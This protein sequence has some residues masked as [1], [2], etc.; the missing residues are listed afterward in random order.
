MK[1]KYTVLLWQDR[2]KPPQHSQC[3][4]GDH[5]NMKWWSLIPFQYCFKLSTDSLFK[6]TAK[7]CKCRSPIQKVSPSPQQ[8]KCSLFE[9]KEVVSLIIIFSR[10]FYIYM[11][12]SSSKYMSYQLRTAIFPY[13]FKM[14]KNSSSPLALRLA[15]KAKCFHYHFSYLSNWRPLPET[16]KEDKGRSENTFFAFF[17]FYKLCSAKTWKPNWLEVNR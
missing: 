6:W 13:L 2:W 9:K 17:H 16:I 15:Y 1:I 12:Y 5:K 11:F 14:G 7:S 3:K 8:W 4:S 10:L